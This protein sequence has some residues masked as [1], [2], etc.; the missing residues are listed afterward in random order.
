MQKYIEIKSTGELVNGT[1]QLNEL[2]ARTLLD[3]IGDGSNPDLQTEYGFFRVLPSLSIRQ[4][5]LYREDNKICMHEPD[6]SFFVLASEKTWN[7]LLAT[8]ENI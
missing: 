1:I 5:L 4:D 6:P 3:L 2:T 7:N 8:C